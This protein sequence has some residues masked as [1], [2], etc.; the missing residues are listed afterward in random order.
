MTVEEREQ[1]W[2]EAMRA[3]RRGEAVD[4]SA[5]SKKLRQPCVDRLRRASFAWASAR[6]RLKI[7]CRRYS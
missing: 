3:E 6:M 7:W 4:M 5:C 1:R 2:A